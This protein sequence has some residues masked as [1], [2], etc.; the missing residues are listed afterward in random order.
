MFEITYNDSDTLQNFIDAD[1][2]YHSAI[3]DFTFEGRFIV[4]HFFVKD[5]ARY[6][7][8]DSM[9]GYGSEITRRRKNNLFD[10]R[11]Y[12]S[13]IPMV[14][15]AI[16]YTGDRRY[17]NILDTN[18]QEI[19]ETIFRVMLP[20][21]GFAV[22]EEQ[23]NLSKDMYLGLTTKQVAICEAE[24]GTGKTL[25]YLVA[26]FVAQRRYATEYGFLLPVTVSTSSIELQKMIVEK[27]IPQLSRALQDY[28]IIKHPL[29]AVVRKGKEHYFCKARYDDYF[30]KISRNED[31]YS[32]LI[33]FF[34]DSKVAS[35]AFDLDQWDMPAAIKGKMNVKGKCGRCAYRDECR[36]RSFLKAANE[37]GSVDFQVTNHNMFLMS[38][39]AS[40]D[41][42]KI[43]IIQDSPYVVIDESHKLLEAAQ[44]T[45]G[46]KFSEGL[47]QKYINS[48][49]HLNASKEN[50]KIFSGMLSTAQ[51]NNQQLF[52]KL[53]KLL[54]DGAFDDEQGYNITLPDSAVTHI[55]KLIETIHHIETYRSPQRGAYDVDGRSIAKILSRFLRQNNKHIWLEQEDNGP[56]SLCCCPKN[57]ADILEKTV[58]DKCRSYI[59]TSG[60]MSDG[61][62]F[63]FFKKENGISRLPKH[64]VS[65]KVTASPFDYANHTRLYIPSDMPAPDNSSGSY[66]AAVSDKILKL[67][68]AT[69][70]H[71][72]I[73][74]TS[75][76]V[77]Q[78]VYERTAPKLKKYDIFCMT[79]N[80]RTVISEFRK[81][82]NGVLFA[83][84]S[85]WEGV[86]CIGDGLSSVIIV[87]L[88]FPLRSAMMEQ[89]KEAAG[90]VIKF[91]QEY[92]LPE[93]LIK[94]RQGAGRLIRCESD[95]G[96]I[97]ILDSRADKSG[98][99]GKIRMA[100]SKYPSVDSIDEI[101]TFMESVKGADYYA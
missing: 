73:L 28:G 78:A 35:R 6:V 18:P 40:E 41:D 32:K 31:K 84:G 27:E 75:Y 30:E 7:A 19:I 50:E 12:Q 92:A 96:V 79:R 65:E 81:S 11:S 101:R 77:L 69:N 89:K 8:L 51:K 10:S 62:D 4:Y 94:L 72:A 52:A 85:M 100:L 16:K 34:N 37:K 57:M 88:P 13:M 71:T 56:L 68:D 38:I 3:Y 91:I 42:P 2:A 66:I 58:W 9:T 29:S 99:V 64:L 17:L 87:R 55:R 53:R 93:M 5:V 21:Y 86:D 46:E 63:S 15:D 90:D 24:V 98:Y 43:R 54:P 23:I 14:L 26:A 39:K 25:A 33:E 60:T 1:K 70:G 61:T 48:V 67:V 45:F 59:L 36:Y 80:K 76:K 83:S 95:T 20:E 44:G 47:I 97:S 82:K 74:F 22:R 49:K